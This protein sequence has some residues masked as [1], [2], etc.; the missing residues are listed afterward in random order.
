[1]GEDTYLRQHEVTELVGLKAG[2][3]WKGEKRGT[4]PKRIKLTG[5]S[6]VLWSKRE[7]LQWVA[8]AAARREAKP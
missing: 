5:S 8:D 1:M 6:R 7:I 2:A 4:F 3:I